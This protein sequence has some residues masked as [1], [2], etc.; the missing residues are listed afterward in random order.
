MSADI[1]REVWRLAELLE[2]Q[3]VDAERREVTFKT[4]AGAPMTLAASLSYMRAVL[5]NGY[6]HARDPELYMQSLYRLAE[7][8]RDR[9]ER[10]G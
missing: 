4:T 6:A 1:D 10:A 5:V 3:R 2:A 9:V 7:Q 8:Y